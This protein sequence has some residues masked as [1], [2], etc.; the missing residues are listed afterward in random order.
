[1]TS[2]T[3]VPDLIH[4]VGHGATAGEGVRVQRRFADGTGQGCGVCPARTSATHVVRV[5]RSVKVDLEDVVEEHFS[6]L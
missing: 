3:W 5:D 6:Y 4:G 2:H 1:M